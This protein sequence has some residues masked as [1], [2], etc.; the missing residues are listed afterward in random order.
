MKTLYH[1]TIVI[2]RIG[3]DSGVR[4][5]NKKLDPVPSRREPSSNSCTNPRPTK[6]QL[7]LN[8]LVHRPSQVRSSFMP[9]EQSPSVFPSPHRNP[10]ASNKSSGV[11]SPRNPNLETGQARKSIPRQLHLQQPPKQ[12]YARDERAGYG[13]ACWLV[14]L[15]VCIHFFFSCMSYRWSL[16]RLRGNRVTKS[17]GST[18]N[19]GSDYAW[20]VRTVRHCTA[21]Q[22][23]DIGK[24]R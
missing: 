11:D 13:S 8:H 6:L 16:F 10:K 9:V 15:F 7:Q 2:R 3:P 1:F 23:L 21:L 5:P 14:C 20:T 19:S 4:S 17:P 12:Y 22:L 18:P 24:E